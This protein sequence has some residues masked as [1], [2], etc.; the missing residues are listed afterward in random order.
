MSQENA[1]IVRRGYKAWREQ[2]LDA[3]LELL[4]PDFEFLP[5]ISEAD[6]EEVYRGA[7]GWRDFVA[8]WEEVW[9][10]STSTSRGS[11]PSSVSERLSSQDHVPW[12]RGVPVIEAP[13]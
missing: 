6:L 9:A 7:D 8:T 5:F 13:F 4:A 1:E 11:E 2:D 12:E 10:V 3:L